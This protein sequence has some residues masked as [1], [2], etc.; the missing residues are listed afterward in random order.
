MPTIH[1]PEAFL[2]LAQHLPVADVRS[3]GEYAHGHLPGAVNLPLFTNEQRAE[4]GTLYKQQGQEL[5]MLRGLEL[6][7]PR[8]ADLVRGATELAPAKKILL[9][10]WRGGMRSGSLAWLL[11]TFGFE[12]G[13]LAGGYKAYRHLVLQDFYV[14]RQLVILGGRTGSAKT[15]VL[16]QLRALGQQVIDLEALAHHKGSVFGGLGQ[17][18]QPLVEEF[19]NRLHQLWAKTDPSLPLW[20]EDESHALGRIYL[21]QGLWQQM[22]C[23]PVVDLAVPLPARVGHLVAHYGGFGPELLA[24]AAQKIHK[25][26]GPQTTNEVLAALQASDHA[27]AASLMLNYYDRAYDHGLHTRTVPVVRVE[28][29]TADAATNAKLVLAALP[30]LGFGQNV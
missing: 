21:P 8:L 19:E 25:R 24:G 16:H 11:G 20:L 28:T 23:A 7:G 13:L 9:H 17:P 12:V 26:L 3:P 6:A 27:Q 18:A 4:V 14:P 30:R 2:Q 5:A 29:A 22:Q 1:S 15:E 10:C